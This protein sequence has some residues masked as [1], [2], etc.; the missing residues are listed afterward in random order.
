MDCA[1]LEKNYLNAQKHLSAAKCFTD[2][3]SCLKNSKNVLHKKMLVCFRF[4]V[5][6]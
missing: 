2:E 4:H 3:C 5:K 1:S 6:A